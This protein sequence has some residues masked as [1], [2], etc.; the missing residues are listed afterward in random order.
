MS[1]TRAMSFV[2]AVANILMGYGIALATQLMVFP[3]FGLA[4]TL[5]DNLLIGAIFTLVSLTRSYLLRRLFNAL[6]VVQDLRS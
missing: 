5:R 4:A 1:Q 2:E 6:S 3:L